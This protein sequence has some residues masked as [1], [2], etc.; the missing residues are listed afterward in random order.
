MIGWLDRPRVPPIASGRFS[1]KYAGLMKLMHCRVPKIGFE[2]HSLCSSRVGGQSFCLLMAVVFLS[3]CATRRFVE[4]P[5]QAGGGVPTAEVTADKLILASPVAGFALQT[6]N[7][8]PSQDGVESSARPAVDRHVTGRAVGSGSTEPLENWM[9]KQLGPDVVVRSGKG[10]GLLITR[11]NRPDAKLPLF[12]EAIVL[13][14]LRAL[15]R[16][17]EVKQA[18]QTTFRNGV[19]STSLQSPLRS[20]NAVTVI[21]KVL[22]Y[23]E[24]I[25][26]RVTSVYTGE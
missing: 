5:S 13:G 20:R 3:A 15:V 4:Y 23:P 18:G 16:S 2:G 24:V 14:Q 8:L 6:V 21:K 1:G 11:P 26:L 10:G 9:A 7:R 19:A 17:S 12:Q 22:E 25:E